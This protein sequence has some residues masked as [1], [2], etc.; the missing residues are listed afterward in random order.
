MKLQRLLLMSFF[1]VAVSSMSFAANIIMP[2]SASADLSMSAYAGCGVPVTAS[3]PN[4]WGTPLSTLMSAPTAISQ[5]SSPNRKVTTSGT[6][7]ATWTNNTKKGKIIFS[8]IGWTANANV[9]A[10]SANANLGSDYTYTFMPLTEIQFDMTYDI[11]ANN[12][13]TSNFGLNGFYIDL[14]TSGWNGLY[15]VGSSGTLSAILWPNQTYTLT[16]ANG[17]NISGYLAGSKEH[18]D[19]KFNFVAAAVPEPTSMLLM[20]GGILALAGALRKKMSR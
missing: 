9:T 6:L 15:G 2:L 20:G 1:V 19:G 5:C 4:A 13:N 16:I 3:D 11:S 12:N 17:A 8:N 7:D 18:M 10:G 14:T